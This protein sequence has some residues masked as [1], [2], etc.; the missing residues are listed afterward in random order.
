MF[1]NGERELNPSLVANMS[2]HI[3]AHFGRTKFLKHFV[4]EIDRYCDLT[5]FTVDDINI[6]K[7]L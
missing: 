1:V 4:G 5:C 7:T 2:Y 6:S 3:N